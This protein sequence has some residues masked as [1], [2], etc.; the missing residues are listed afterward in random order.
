MQ[1]PN[2]TVGVQRG[3]EAPVKPNTAPGLSASQTVQSRANVSA[4]GKQPTTTQTDAAAGEA[5]AAAATKS[6]SYAPPAPPAP[7]QANV[8]SQARK[9]AL[10][11]A[12][13]ILKEVTIGKGTSE[14]PWALAGISRDTQGALAVADALELSVTGN[15]KNTMKFL[16]TVTRNNDS[17]RGF[18]YALA[19]AASVAPERAVGIML[20]LTDAPGGRD[21]VSKMFSAFGQDHQAS[22]NMATVLEASSRTPGAAR[23]MLELM[24]VMTQPEGDNWHHATG[25]AESLAKSTEYVHGSRHV[26]QSLLNTMEVEGGARQFG[27]LLNRMSRTKEGAQATSQ[28]LLN[29]SYDRE[30]AQAVGRMLQRA[31]TSRSGGAEVLDSLNRMANAQGGQRDVARLL[32]RLAQTPEGGRFMSN[33]FKDEIHSGGLIDLMNRLSARED[34]RH[35]L[36]QAL[37]SIFSSRRTIADAEVIRGRAATDTDLKAALDRA[38]TSPSSMRQMP[39]PTEYQGAMTAE[40]SL[41]RA[42][43]D[44]I[45]LIGDSGPGLVDVTGGA[46]KPEGKAPTA[47]LTGAPKTAA[48]EATAAPAEPTRESTPVKPEEM[49]FEEEPTTRKAR[50]DAMERL[51]NVREQVFTENVRQIQELRAARETT[52]TAQTTQGREAHRSEQAQQ[53]DREDRSYTFRPGDVYSEDTLKML[54][55]CAECGFRT[56]SAGLCPRCASR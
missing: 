44:R 1:D 51:G 6:T 45:D 30:G 13:N 31:T 10:Q 49:H 21:A 3:L 26:A 37:D 32:N 7:G 14:H 42:T 33:L 22:Q 15:A 41:L 34:S 27:T 54:R 35:F 11:Q 16:D 56:T 55:I 23:G 53:T 43:Q 50:Q 46:E 25:L 40:T 52:E 18:S 38:M 20:L 48:P 12:S 28:T 19:N 5:A 8:M 17:T 24:D 36:N 39:D 2:L 47:P 4:V 9:Q 29:M